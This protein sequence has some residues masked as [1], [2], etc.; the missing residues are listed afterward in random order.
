MLNKTPVQFNQTQVFLRFVVVIGLLLSF[1]LSFFYMSVRSLVTTWTQDHQAELLF[2]QQQLVAAQLDQVQDHLKQLAEATELQ[3]YLLNPERI[4]Q[5]F[6]VLSLFQTHLEDNSIVYLLDLDGQVLVSTYP[7]LVSKDYSFRDYFQVPLSSS[8]PHI[9]VNKGVTT[10][11]VG[12]YFS[13]PVITDSGAVVGVIVHK[14]NSQLLTE[15]VS[16]R[17]NDSSMSSAVW[18]TDR[19]GVIIAS[20]DPALFLKAVHPLDQ[21]EKQILNRDHYT[22]LT[23]ENALTVDRPADDQAV[24]HQ[25]AIDT[26]ANSVLVSTRSVDSLPLLIGSSLS[27]HQITQQTWA[28][29]SRFIRLLGAVVVVFL[30]FTYFNLKAIRQPL[31][32]LL[33]WSRS[34]NTKNYHPLDFT[35]NSK[36]LAELAD[37]LNTFNLEFRQLQ[38]KL[39]SRTSTQQAQ[40]QKLNALMTERELKMIELKKQLQEAKAQDNQD[41]T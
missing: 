30:T 22:D 14:L 15:L 25:L 17:P 3:T 27:Y 18:V 37:N 9:G 35:G 34:F 38:D 16:A 2:S 33:E 19:Y 21:P 5:D 41:S 29:F 39:A 24:H 40:V 8:V 13:Q 1:L 20:S 26:Q 32:V 23:I 31:N 4:Q 7:D 6:T 10:N 12:L 36:V 11:Q 28:I